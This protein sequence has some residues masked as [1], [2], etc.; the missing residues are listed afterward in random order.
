MR[1]AALDELKELQ[2]IQEDVKQSIHALPREW[3]QPAS[4]TTAE[5]SPSGERPPGYVPAEDENKD[6]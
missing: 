6:A 3:I 1:E 4:G 5:P 2:Q